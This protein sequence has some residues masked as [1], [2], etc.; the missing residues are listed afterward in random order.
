VCG[1]FIG[2]IF[3]MVKFED[4]FSFL[5]STI[6]ITFVFYLF[7]HVVLIFF[8]ADKDIEDKLFDTKEYESFSNDQISE[9]KSRED[10]ITAILKSIHG[11]ETSEKEGV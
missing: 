6:T 2:M 9:I 4:A 10:K 7:I 5:F 11:L 3:S 1:F 8:L